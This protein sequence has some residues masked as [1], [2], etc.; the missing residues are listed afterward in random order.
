VLKGGGPVDSDA[1]DVLGRHGTGKMSVQNRARLLGGK[2]DDVEAVELPALNVTI[3]QT[4]IGKL[5]PI[6]DPAGPALGHVRHEAL[7]EADARRLQRVRHRI[8]GGG[9]RV[10]REPQ[11]LSDLGDLFPRLAP[12]RIVPRAR[13]CH[14]HRTITRP[15]HL[16]STAK[17][18]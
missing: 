16:R 6:E 7:I 8:G 15:I 12:D 2:N 3:R 18:G 14:R 13:L 11:I 5:V 10:K 17:A 9:E 1:S 4:L